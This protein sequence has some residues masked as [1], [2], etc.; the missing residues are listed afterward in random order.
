[1]FFAAGSITNSLDWFCQTSKKPQ[2]VL[3]TVQGLVIEF[4]PRHPE[5]SLALFTLR[6]PPGRG[7]STPRSSWA[8]SKGGEHNGIIEG[9][10]ATCWALQNGPESSFNLI[11]NMRS[12]ISGKGPRMFAFKLCSSLF[13]HCF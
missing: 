8:C 2:V 9:Q 4:T 5:G 13:L 11:I 12:L 1:M 7:H 10:K 6:E 3:Q